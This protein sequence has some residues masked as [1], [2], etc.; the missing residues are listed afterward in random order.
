M[1][2]LHNWRYNNK[3]K[4]LDTIAH[5]RVFT[6]TMD[7]GSYTFKTSFHNKC[8]K[9]DTFIYKINVYIGCDSSTASLIDFVKPE[10]KLIGVY[11][12]MGRPVP[13]IRNEEILI[14]RYDDGTSK[15]ILINQ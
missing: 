9:C 13:Y 7:T 1:Y 4:K 14:Y 10:P 8:G 2:Y 11:D 12:M 5:D 6:R 15:K 3:T